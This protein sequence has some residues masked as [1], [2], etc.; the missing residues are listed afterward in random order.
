LI[1]R[2][3]SEEEGNKI[4]MIISPGGK[5]HGRLR[6]VIEAIQIYCVFSAIYLVVFYG[7][8]G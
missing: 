4:T 7:L 6:Y 2:G 8:V 1:S 5:D 3:F